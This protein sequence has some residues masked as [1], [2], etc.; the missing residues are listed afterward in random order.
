MA[1]LNEADF[2]SLGDVPVLGVYV[3]EVRAWPPAQ[4]SQPQISGVSSAGT[5]TVTWAET[6][7]AESYELR[8]NGVTIATQSTRVYTDSGLAWNGQYTY[9]VIPISFGIPGTESAP[10]TVVTIPKGT[11]GTLTPSSRTYTNVTV[12]WAAVPGAT[13]YK[14]YKNGALYATQTGTSKAIATSQ[15]TT[16][17][18]YV[19]PLRNG[20]V[21]NNSATKTYYSGKA[22]VRDQGSKSGMEFIPTRLDSW[23]SVDNWAWLS[24][25]A[26]QGYYTASYGSYR[27]V[28]DFGGSNAI[29]NSLR[30]KLGTNGTNRQLYG[31]CT[32]AEIYLVRKTNTGFQSNTIKVRF[33]L[34]TSAAGSGGDP[35]V[36]KG[37]AWQEHDFPAA[38]NSDTGRWRDLGL[39]N[40]QK[41]GDG[42]FRSVII[43]KDGS[44]N[45][46]HFKNGKIRLSWSWNY[47]LEAAKANTWT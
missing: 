39:G 13:Q 34:C 19:Q 17:T 37:G 18:I 23:R 35:A 36:D 2:V 5:V 11:V 46:A 45:Y 29:R 1:F 12:S 14:I 47:V 4:G 21:G 6:D 38:T 20:V 25:L 3:G 43:K 22:E 27:G 26:A 40:G 15:N 28:I 33:A 9:T 10:S 41:M 8:R 16:I 7:L 42:G 31:N 32:A 30:S 24:G 44:A